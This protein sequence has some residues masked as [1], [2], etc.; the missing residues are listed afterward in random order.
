MANREN[1]KKVIDFIFFDSK[2]TVDGD[3]SHSVKR[4]LLFG[5]KAMTSLA[6]ILKSR[7]ITLLTKVCIVKSMFFPVIMYRYET[8]T[9]RKTEYQSIDA[10]ELWPLDCKE[11]KPV[12]PKGNQPWI[13]IGRTDADAEAEAPVVWPPDVESW[14]LGKDPDAG[15]DW[16][17]KKGTTKIRWLDGITD[18][19][20]TGLSKLREVVRDRETWSA[21]VLGVTKSQRQPSHWTT[22]TTILAKSAHVLLL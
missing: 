1:M 2:I 12:N 17:Q 9:I 20:N 18:S 10:F 22:T 7:D 21:S 8:W 5:R 4:L 14:L 13:F 11:I 6:S 15:K 19:V 16:R 3:C